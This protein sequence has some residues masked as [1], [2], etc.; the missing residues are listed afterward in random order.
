MYY[1]KTQNIMAKK[2]GFWASL[3]APKSS[4][5]C[6]DNIVVEEIEMEKP[7]SCCCG[8]KCEDAKGEKVTDIKVLG[9]GCAKCVNTYHAFEKVIE[10]NNLDIKLTKIDDVVE[11]MSYNVMS[12]PAVVV[13]GK[14][15][16]KGYVPSESEIKEILGL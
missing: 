16:I 15:R 11:I 8:G 12:T 4:C 5:C 13:N 14:V 6:G 10:E 3:F 2:K 7:A 1:F 9:P